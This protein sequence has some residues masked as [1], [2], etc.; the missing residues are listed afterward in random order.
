MLFAKTRVKEIPSTEQSCDINIHVGRCRN[1]KN[2]S[3]KMT[4][5][6]NCKDS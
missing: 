4:Q 2:E 5:L 3:I 6:L 1:D